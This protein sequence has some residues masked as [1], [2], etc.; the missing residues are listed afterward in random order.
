[1]KI[2]VN[3]TKACKL[4]TKGVLKWMRDHGFSERLFLSEGIDEDE[5]LKVDD[6]RVRLVI[7]RAH[8]GV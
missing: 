3:H 5:L 4:C 6:Q 1:M 7:R 2:N 8:Q